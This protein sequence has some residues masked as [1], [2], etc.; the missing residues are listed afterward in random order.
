[1]A[2]IAHKLK[3][4]AKNIL[5]LNKKVYSADKQYNLVVSDKGRFDRKIAVVTG[6]TGA[7]GKATCMRLLAE[8]CTVYIS[9]RSKEKI[10]NLILNLP[11]EIK[12]R[13]S[14]RLMVMNV[15]DSDS[16]ESAF[17]SIIQQEGRI[18][19]LVN[20]AGGGARERARPLY[21]QE[22]DVIDEI[23]QTNLRGSILCA[24]MASKIM[25][26]NN[27]GKIVNISSSIGV[28]G[29]ERC[30][31]YSASK[32]G[33]FGFTKSLAK[34]LGRFGINVNCV[35][36]GSIVRGDY[37]IDEAEYIKETNYLHSI[38]TLEDVANVIVFMVSDEAKFI[39]GQNIIVDGGRTLG[40]KGGG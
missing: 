18:D 11:D 36:P 28:N 16:I 20:C 17:S 29:M 32:S 9:G 39:T 34:E 8:G 35:T 37:S 22:V 25:K 30:V 40:I 3:E 12:N 26:K 4:S 2:S 6:G 21:D 38:G 19:I 24:R 15:S 14:A 13:G 23:L 1:M 5:G 10:E 27:Y 31:D 33:M 7:I